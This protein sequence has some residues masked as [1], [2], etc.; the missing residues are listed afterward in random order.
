MYFPSFEET[1]LLE[2]NEM[3]EDSSEIFSNFIAV[4]FLSQPNENVDFEKIL[5]GIMETISNKFHD[6]HYKD[7]LQDSKF[8]EKKEK[9]KIE[10]K[11][12]EIFYYT[13]SLKGNHGKNFIRITGRLWLLHKCLE[14]I[15]N[16][17]VK[18][19][20]YYQCYLFKNW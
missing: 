1:I 9:K 5:L 2:S 18:F 15:E 12:V 14:L 8:R 6:Y 16:V 17:M 13:K 20:H 3:K 19:F 7:F 11:N 4:K 10:W